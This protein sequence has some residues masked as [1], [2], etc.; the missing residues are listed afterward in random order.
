MKVVVIGTGFGGYAVAPAWKALGWEVELVS[1]RDSRAV[2]RAIATPCDLVSIHSPPFMHLEHVDLAVANRR[3]VLCDK[4]FG[5]S[6]EEARQMLELARAGGVLHFLNF[7]FRFDPLRQKMQELV[8]AGQI[9]TPRHFACSMFISRGRNAPHGWLFEKE[10]G[11]G[12]IGAFASHHVDALH[13]LFGKVAEAACLPRIDQLTRPGRNDSALH[14][15][16]AEDAVT[17]WFRMENGVTSSLDTTASAALDSLN[18]TTLLGTDGVLELRNNAELALR[19]P[20]QEDELYTLDAGRN[21]MSS[22][23]EIWFSQVEAAIRSGKPAEP[24]FTAGVAC[25]EVLDSMRS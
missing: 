22:A 25:A 6:A 5:R 1:P 11:G 13:W 24:D 15:A 10:T 2:A 18:M 8:A 9:G 4:P 14:T 7:E 3:H 23:L 19:R 20:G 17:A 16:T 12:W 21:A